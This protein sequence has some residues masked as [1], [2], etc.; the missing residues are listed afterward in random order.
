MTSKQRKFLRSKAHQLKP[1]IIIGKSNINTSIYRTFDH[2]LN[3]HEL[4][5]V[6]FN[7]F[8]D[9]KLDVLEKIN[10]KLNF[11]TVGIIGNTAIIFRQNKNVEDQIYK[12]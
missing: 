6:K 9:T 7:N 8:K 3:K 12:L 5:K 2:C 10:S 11:E 4:I 1:V